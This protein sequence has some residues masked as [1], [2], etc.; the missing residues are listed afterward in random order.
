[1]LLKFF[2]ENFEAFSSEV[3]LDLEADLRTKKF[4][5]NVIENPQGNALKSIAIFGPNNTGKTCFINAIKAYRD[6]LLNKRNVLNSNFFSDSFVVKLGSEFLYNGERYKYYFCYNTEN[7]TFVEE[8]FSNIV[9]DE[10][11]NATKKEFFYRNTETKEVDSSSKKL[12]SIMNLSAK[13]N[14]LINTLDTS[15]LPLLEYARRILRSFSESITVLSMDSLEPYKTIEMLKKGSTRESLQLIELIRNA[16]IDIDDYRYDEKMPENILNILKNR[17]EKIKSKLEVDKIT[18]MLKLTSVHRGVPMPSM[19]YDSLGTKNIVSLA[20][21]L[22]ECLNNGGVLFIDELD[23][24]IHFKLSRAIVS[25]FNNS[26]NTKGQLIFTTHDA[27]LLDTRTLFR[28]EQLWFTSR[29]D[30]DVY[31]YPLSSFTV[32]NSGIRADSNLYDIYSKGLV[33]AVPDPSLIDI[34]ISESSGDA[35]E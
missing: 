6:I 1:M 18:E 16:D 4:L 8:E 2:I 23:S 14:V 11:G 20:S 31:L 5:S 28:K 19:L 35:N 27:S 13:D 29:E 15:E 30:G 33:G 7:D 24:S 17:G 9:I 21:Y 3:E 12:K 22:V 34:L 26:L 32:E 25:L 10:Y